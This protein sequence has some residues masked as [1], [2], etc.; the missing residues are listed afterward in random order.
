MTHI[1]WALRAIKFEAVRVSHHC[2]TGLSDHS[3]VTVNI[4]SCWVSNTRYDSCG[5][6]AFLLS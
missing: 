3:F 2:L 6:L 1:E 4:S 5:K